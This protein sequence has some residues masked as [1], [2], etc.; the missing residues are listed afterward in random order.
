MLPVQLD[1]MD[2][3]LV[4]LHIESVPEIGEFGKNGTRVTVETTVE[5]IQDGMVY[6]T[7]S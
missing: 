4:A 5:V 2:V 1:Q 7:N 3:M 6:K